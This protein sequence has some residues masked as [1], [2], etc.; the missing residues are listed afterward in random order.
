[1][2]PIPLLQLD[3]SV[4]LHGIDKA[5]SHFEVRTYTCTSIP[6]H[7]MDVHANAWTVHVDCGSIVME[8]QYKFAVNWRLSLSVLG[9]AWVGVGL[10]HA[11][12]LS[13]MFYRLET[14]SGSCAWL[15]VTMYIQ[16]QLWWCNVEMAGF[17]FG[18]VRGWTPPPLKMWLIFPKYIYKH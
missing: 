15:Q 16:W 12:P 11:Q 1:M 6:I 14:T 4:P 7:I 9:V 13:C 8:I 3:E 2:Q 5:I 17:H 10:P 18:G